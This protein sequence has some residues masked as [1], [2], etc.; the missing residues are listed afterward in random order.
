VLLHAPIASTANTKTK[1]ESSHALTA[2]PESFQRMSMRRNP[3][4]LIAVLDMFKPLQDRTT[5]TPSVSPGNI[6]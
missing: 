6:L 1:Q 2:R 5:A 4:A 3:D